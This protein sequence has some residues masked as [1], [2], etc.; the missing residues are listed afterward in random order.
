MKNP[1]QN[2]QQNP[3]PNSHGRGGEIFTDFQISF[4]PGFGAY[5]SLAQKIKVPF[6]RIFSFFLQFW[7]FEGDFKTRAKPRYAPNSGWN[8]FRDFFCKVRCVKIYGKLCD[9][10]VSEKQR[11]FSRCRVVVKRSPKDPAVLNPKGPNLEKIQDRLKITRSLENFNLAW[12]F[13]SWPPEFPTEIGVWWVA[14]L[15]IS[16]SLENFKILNFFKIWALRENT[17]A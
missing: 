3:Q 6:S 15:K 8:A 9:T 11:N 10:L 4:K 14:R 17:T 13:Q 5:Q 12:N 7:G 2:S 1:W 16:S